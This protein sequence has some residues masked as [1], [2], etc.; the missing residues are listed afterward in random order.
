MPGEVL[1]IL[2]FNLDAEQHGYLRSSPTFDPVLFGVLDSFQDDFW[3]AANLLDS[4]SINSQVNHYGIKTS[5]WLKCICWSKSSS[6]TALH[7]LVDKL[8]P[9]CS[10]RHVFACPC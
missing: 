2:Y 6:S 7:K 5:S 4:I 9:M 1:S 10:S 3:D 8:E